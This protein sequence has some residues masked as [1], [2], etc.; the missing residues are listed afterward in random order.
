MLGLISSASYGQTGDVKGVI[1]DMDGKP[2]PS[3]NVL[4]LGTTIGAATDTNGEF[5]IQRVPTGSYRVRASMLGYERKSLDI[6]IQD[7]QTVILYFEL[8]A[9]SLTSGELVVTATRRSQLIGSVPV[10]LSTLEGSS[11]DSR[12]ILTLDD[13]LRVTPGI[14]LAGNQVNIRGSSGFSYGVGSRVLLLVDGVPLLGPDTGD[15]RFDGLPMT[16]VDR[17]E[18]VKGPGSALY[19]SGALG[20]VVNLITRGFPQEPQSSIRVFGGAYQPFRHEQWKLSWD[21][22]DQ[23]RPLGGI[24]LSHAHQVSESFGFW[25]NGLYRQ[26]TGYLKQST[27]QGVELHAKLGWKF[28]QGSRLELL[29]GFKRYKRDNFLYWN[30]INDPLVPGVANLLDGSA[31]AGTNDGLSDQLSILPVWTKVVSQNFSYSL[32]GRVFGVA[33]RPLDDTTGVIRPKV[34]HNRGLRYGGEAQFNVTASPSSQLTFGTAFDANAAKSEFYIGVD[35]LMAR[36]QPE[37]GLYGQ[38]EQQLGSQITFSA[39]LRYDGYKVHREEFASKTSPKVSMSWVPATFLTLRASYGQG[40]RVPSVAER[41]TSNREFF[42]VESNLALLPEES[43]GFEVGIHLNAGLGKRAAVE[44]DVA[45]FQNTYDGLI[46]A[47]FVPTLGAFQ[48]QNLT[49]ARIRGIETSL[50]AGTL[51]NRQ[52]VSLSYTLLDA[53]DLK[54]DKPLNQRSRHL[55][56]ASANSYLIGP[57]FIGT[58]YRYA[59]KT[60]AIDSDLGRFVKNASARV[61]VSVLDLRVGIDKDAG[62]GRAGYRLAF[63]LKNVTDQYY[64]ERPA[65]LAPPR[66]GMLQLEVMF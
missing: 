7:G 45:T 51:N 24:V 15:I 5:L 30:G 27:D 16:Q 39:G 13:A 64:T 11:I 3:V 14:Q 60:E 59:S 37:I 55:F 26:D 57:L 62:M 12:N 25:V 38:L 42:P 53:R 56:I 65:Y 10:T 36:Q 17:I 49:E 23:Y 40:F 41:F 44:F 29:T 46:E 34:K 28:D 8:R 6:V 19:G 33:F 43:D 32:K 52:K 9:I 2:L 4:L 61:P 20:G 58:D 21:E 47:V 48:F 22:A 18:V 54:L 1:T 66:H 35:S 50:Q 63:I 31:G